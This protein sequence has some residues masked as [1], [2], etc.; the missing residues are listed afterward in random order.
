MFPLENVDVDTHLISPGVKIHDKI[1]GLGISVA[2]LALVAVGV[3]G[4]L[5]G[6]VSVVL[7]LGQQLIILLV[8]LWRST[9]KRL[10]QDNRGLARP[11]GR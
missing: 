6:H 11:G 2:H 5:L 8:I 4:H 10:S 9:L 1:L 3:P 7:V